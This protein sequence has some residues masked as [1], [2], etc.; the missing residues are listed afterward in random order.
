MKQVVDDSRRPEPL[1]VRAEYGFEEYLEEAEQNLESQGFGLE[2]FVYQV[3]ASLPPLESY[4][5]VKSHLDGRNAVYVLVMG[6]DGEVRETEMV[7]LDYDWEVGNFD[8]YGEKIDEL[9]DSTGFS[10]QFWSVGGVNDYIE[11]EDA[12]EALRNGFPLQATARI[13]AGLEEPVSV[14]W[15]YRAPM[16]NTLEFGYQCFKRREGPNAEE[17]ENEELLDETLSK[18]TGQNEEKRNEHYVSSEE[19]EVLLDLE[20]EMRELNII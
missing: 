20:E 12:F 2:G 15:F 5:D 3:N 8:V 10:N 19:Q 6:T 18:I 16:D 9:I 7:T 13:E 4:E 17:L 14:G 1:S 11:R